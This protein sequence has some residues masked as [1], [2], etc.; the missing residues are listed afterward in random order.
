MGCAGYPEAT[1]AVNANR[2]KAARDGLASSRRREVRAPVHVR[3]VFLAFYALVRTPFAKA[4]L[5][6]HRLVSNGRRNLP[7]LKI[8]GNQFIGR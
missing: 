5:R 6:G 2:T 7:V 3:R 1:A 8:I 4:G